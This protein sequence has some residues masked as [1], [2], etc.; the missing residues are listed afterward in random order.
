MIRK[1]RSFSLIAIFLL[2]LTGCSIET[3][4]NGKLDGRWQ[5]IGS[6]L[7]RWQQQN[8]KNERA[9]NLLGYTI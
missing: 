1:M 8:S 7:F 2:L 4:D 6:K 9:T 3:S 5:L